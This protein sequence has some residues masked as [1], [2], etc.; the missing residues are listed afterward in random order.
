MH[1]SPS[2]WT[3]LTTFSALCSWGMGG[4]HSPLLLLPGEGDMQSRRQVRCGRL[5]EPARQAPRNPLAKKEQALHRGP[6]LSSWDGGW[7][8]TP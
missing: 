3:L 5:M 6:S 4:G 8:L 7:G 2:E 1:Y